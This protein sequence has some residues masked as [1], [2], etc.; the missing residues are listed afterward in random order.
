MVRE[1]FVS[2]QAIVDH[3][4]RGGVRM[5]ANAKSVGERNYE[6]FAR[7]YAEYALTKAHNAYYDR[8]AVLSLLPDVNGKRVLDAGCGPGI[9][10]EL[11]L[12]R[13]AQV[14]SFD[15]TPA[16]VEI[17]KER[18]GD[19]ATVLRADMQQ[20]L[21]FAED[22]SF[23]VVVAPLV[24]DYVENWG[25]VF[26]EF[27]RV[28]KPGGLFIFSCGHPFG[29]WLWLNGK[30]RVEESYF[31]TH[32]FTMPWGGFGDPK[33]VITSFRRPLNAVISPLLEAG[34]VLDKLLEPLPTEEFKAA[35][36]DGYA[37]LMREPGFMCVRGRK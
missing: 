20:P 37:R 3:V 15:V 14:V 11:L 19:R 7:R 30:R 32:S 9:Y 5:E 28:L 23:D 25:P 29:D 26:A 10:A 36:P 6:Q 35:D 17:T 24:L 1:W 18:V 27:Y 12:E 22:N 34:F 33:P 21:T 2:K 31:D 13:G 16:F 4:D 8:P